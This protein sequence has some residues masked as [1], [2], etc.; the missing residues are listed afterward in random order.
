[1]ATTGG[2]VGNHKAVTVKKARLSVKK[3]KTVKIKAK[4]VPKSAKLKVKKHR[5]L[6]Y[7]S[8]NTKVATVSGTGSVKGVGKGTCTVYVYAQNGLLKKVK[9]TVK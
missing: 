7:E 8:S 1:M 5:S 3:G 9:I 6:K 4:A 2:T